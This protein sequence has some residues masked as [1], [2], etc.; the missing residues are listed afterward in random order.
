[1]YHIGLLIV[2]GS[3]FEVVVKL[4]PFTALENKYLDMQALIQ[5]LRDDPDLAPIPNSL[6]PAVI[7]VLFVC[8]GC[9]FISFFNGLGK[10]S[11]LATLFEYSEF[12]CSN[13]THT[14]GTLADTDPNSNGI[15]SFLGLWGVH[16]LENIR[17][18]SYPHT[19]HPCHFLS[20][21]Q[22]LTRHT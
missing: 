5:A 1:M 13:S 3:S 22:K 10:A 4:S 16:I 7:Q 2:T 6:S 21:W 9:D 18:H 15:L 8:T 12:I 14:P 17:Q 19:P 20:H 11:F